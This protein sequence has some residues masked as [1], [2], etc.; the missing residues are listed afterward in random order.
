MTQ[1]ELVKLAFEARENAYTP[2][3]HFKVGAIVLCK[4]GRTFAGANIENASYGATNCAER[5]AIFSAYSN[6]I[7]KDDIEAMAIVA[8]DKKIAAPCGICRQ[9]L[10]ELLN[11]DTPI[12]LSNGQETVVK[13]IEE[14]LPM[15][16]TMEDLE[17][18]M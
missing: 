2:Y 8:I 10:C 16:F 7:R 13:T 17:D 15:S 14:L 11:P 5:S 9:V 1:E 18:L 12:Y 6:G 4:D 3:S